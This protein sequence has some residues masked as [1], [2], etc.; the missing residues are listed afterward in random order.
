MDD[1]QIIPKID[2]IKIF[3]IEY[4]FLLK[5]NLIDNIKNTGTIKNEEIPKVLKTRQYDK[6]A[7]KTPNQFFDSSLNVANET[8][9]FTRL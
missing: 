4:S 2:M 1:I 6:N 9:E 7:P 3:D 8:E 5:S